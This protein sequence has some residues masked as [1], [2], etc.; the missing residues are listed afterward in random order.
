MQSV[1]IAELPLYTSSALSCTYCFGR[2]L[3]DGY[4][5]DHH[6]IDE[7]RRWQPRW[8]ITSHKTVGTLAM[9]QHHEGEAL[10]SGSSRETIGKKA[11]DKQIRSADL[12]TLCHTSLWNCQLLLVKYQTPDLNTLST[13]RILR[14][15]RIHKRRV[16]SPNCQSLSALTV[17]LRV[18]AI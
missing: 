2:L 1:I 16:W 8:L 17:T 13:R 4:L 3:T 5:R 14:C 7:W 6:R 9:Y 10:T 12:Q 15:L 11:V 18:F